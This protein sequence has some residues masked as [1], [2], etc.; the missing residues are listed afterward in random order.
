MTLLI[1]KLG[2][3]LVLLLAMTLAAITVACVTAVPRTVDTPHSDGDSNPHAYA[4]THTDSTSHKH[5]GAKP[6]SHRCDR[7]IAGCARTR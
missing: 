5:A 3:F 4:P 1:G 2:P 6:N 7:R